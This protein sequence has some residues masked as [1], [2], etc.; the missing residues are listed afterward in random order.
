MWQRILLENLQLG[1][2]LRKI[3]LSHV[4]KTTNDGEL[5]KGIH[6]YPSRV[7]L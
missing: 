7:L 5:L 6:I 1:N 4:T 3:T 2:W